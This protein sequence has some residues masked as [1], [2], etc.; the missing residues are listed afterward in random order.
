MHDLHNLDYLDAVPSP[1]AL[2]ER[3]TFSTGI[4]W[5]HDLRHL[6]DLHGLPAPLGLAGR[7]TVAT[8]ITW[9]S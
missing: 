1:P 4:T 6:D 7:M 2:L 5:M 3:T 8:W 9:M